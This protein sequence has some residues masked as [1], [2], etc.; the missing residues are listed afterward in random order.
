M[1]VDLF[2]DFATDPKAES[3]GVWEDY[4]DDV[5]F[6]IA[7]SHNKAF[8]RMIV[9]QTTKHRRLLD[10]NNEASEKKGEEIM[11]DTMA[12]TIL[13]GWRGEFNFQ[14]QPMGEYSVEKAKKLLAV[15]DFRQWVN[16][17][18]SDHA[19]FKADQQA[20]DAKK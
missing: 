19:R 18:A 13:L 5:A 3:E 6:L 15:K 14:G 17:V 1:T 11:V 20:A 12:H 4:T 8:D 7:R 2:T 9:A 10:M 16:T